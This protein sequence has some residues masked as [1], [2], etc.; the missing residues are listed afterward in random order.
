[1]VTTSSAARIAKPA[2]NLSPLLPVL[3]SAALLT[4]CG[5]GGGGGSG[6]NTTPS[7]PPPTTSF[8]GTVTMNGT[9]VAGVT[10]IAFNTN[11]S[12]VF[13]T[14]TTDTSGAYSFSG[15]GTSC[16]DNCTSMYQFMAFKQGYA[17]APSVTNVPAQYRNN[18]EWYVP[19][20]GYNSPDNWWNPTGVA[21]TRAGY[22]G[23]YQDPNSIAFPPI[24]FTLFNFSSITAGPNGPVDSITG[25]DFLAYNGTNPLV[26]LAA[27]GQT[28]SYQSGDDA[29]AHTGVAWPVQRFADNGDGSVT[30][31]LTGLIWLKNAGCMAAANWTG[32]MAAAQALASGSC[33]L[34]DGSAAGQW[35]VPN[36]WELESMIDESANAPALTAGNPFVG[37]A[38]NYYWSSTSIFGDPSPTGAPT[39]W[40]IHL[41]T[42]EYT[43]DGV[44]NVKTNALAVWAVKGSSGATVT[45]QA[46]GYYIP[47][48]SGD[49]GSVQGGVP[50]PTTRMVDNGNGTVTD[51]VTGLTWLKQAS[52]AQLQGSWSASLTAVGQL[53]SGQCGLNDGS[54]AGQWRMP[55]RKEMQSLADRI[56]TNEADFFNFT[57]TSTGS[58][59]APMAAVFDN[60]ITL[61]YYWTSS[62]EAANTTNA[63]TVFSCDWGVYPTTKSA[64]GYTLAVR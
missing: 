43:N 1:M 64:T 37:V 28:V 60:F 5:G 21:I 15:M 24:V 30:D 41:G 13:G 33:G 4:A 7:M 39:A 35:R 31:N 42:G 51:S 61:Q 9:P 14:T 49:D 58:A 20:A 22:N 8:A 25:A 10:V 45:L 47:Y 26:H 6:G 38:N 2:S 59:L 34:S 63:W 54:T 40:T 48:A 50:L 18:V 12:K 23:Q 16:T 3:L 19:P 32:A 55:N 56:Q 29:S 62:T 46:T 17:F 52:C 53:A 11:T 27:S 36:V 44:T 57:W